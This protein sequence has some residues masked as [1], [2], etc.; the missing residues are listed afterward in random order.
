MS[1]GSGV[2]DATDGADDVVAKVRALNVAVRKARDHGWRVEVD[3]EASPQSIEETMQS[4]ALRGDPSAP[5]AME[6][7]TALVAINIQRRA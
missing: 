1:L 4:F 3:V 7:T 5:K 2:F 6:P